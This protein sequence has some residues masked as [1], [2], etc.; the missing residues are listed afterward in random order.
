M[1][2]ATAYD[3]ASLPE[4]ALAGTTVCFHVDALPGLLR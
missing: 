2:M 4:L 3:V 1:T